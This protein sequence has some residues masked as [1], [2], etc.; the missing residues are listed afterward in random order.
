VNGSNDFVSNIN[1]VSNIDGNSNNDDSENI[2]KRVFNEKW[3]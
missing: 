2:V 3:Q 1:G